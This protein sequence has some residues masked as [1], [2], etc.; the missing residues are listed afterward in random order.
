[1]DKKGLTATIVFQASSANY[2]ESIGNISTLKKMTRADGKQ[3]VYISRQALRYNIVDQLGNGEQFAKLG[4]DGKDKSVIQFA[5]DATIENSSEIDFFGYMKTASG[6]NATTRGA[7]VRLSNAFAQTPYQG[8]TDFLTNLGLVNRMRKA[9]GDNTIMPNIAQSEVQN[10]FFVYTITID[11]DQVGIDD[12]DDIKLNS[13]EKAK[14][15]DKL[16]TTL[17]YLYRDIRGRREDLKPLFIIG[18]I[19]DIKSPIFENVVRVNS[20]KLDLKAIQS[21]LG[22]PLISENTQ[23]GLVD[24]IFQNDAEI[25]RELGDKLESVSDFMNDLKSKTQNYYMNSEDDD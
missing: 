24:G 18:G 21:T 6:K 11:L 8:D 25:K 16:L 5:K 17:Q 10:D 4:I 3:Y 13:D 7:V 2:G 15:V 19:Y 20:A 23:I 14:R 9:T 22:D 12:N 1:M